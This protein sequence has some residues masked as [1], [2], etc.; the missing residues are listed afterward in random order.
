MKKALLYL[1]LSLLSSSVAAQPKDYEWNSPSANS[2]ESMPCGG[3]DI[4]MNVWVEGGDVLFYLSR[5]GCFDEN[6][7]LLKLGRVRL[8]LSPGLD[9]NHF[10]QVLHLQEGYVEVTDGAISVILWADVMKPVVHVEVES[11]RERVVVAAT[12]ENWRTKDIMM[13]K[14][15]G[16]QSSYKFAMP[17]GLMTHH[18]SIT[19]TDKAVTFWHHNQ[20]QTIFDATVTQ[21][22]MDAIKDK[23]WNPLKGLIFGG[24]M[25]GKG[26][27]MMDTISG[28]YASSDC[29][30]WMLVSER[31]S[32]RHRLEIMLA[33]TQ[34]GKQQWLTE[35]NTI[36]RSIRTD[37]DRKRSRRW[38]RSFWQRS[39][40][41]PVHGV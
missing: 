39:F 3:G 16:F 10:R 26:F 24:R 21:Q 41:F 23:L 15:E 36:E 20:E 35:L 29:L 8:T 38:W 32:R 11:L 4:G 5:S 7:T 25:Q 6:N 33:T 14:R 17:K 27:V 2:S 18:D 22:H 40:T 28:R 37:L 34:G 9:M 12:Y 1:V 13:T 30:G 31:P 19:S